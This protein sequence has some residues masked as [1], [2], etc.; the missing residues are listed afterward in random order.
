MSRGWDGEYP[1][2]CDDQET[3]YTPAWQEKYTCIEGK[4]VLQFAREWAS[5]ALAHAQVSAA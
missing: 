3:P 5:T 1:A 2:D 4:T